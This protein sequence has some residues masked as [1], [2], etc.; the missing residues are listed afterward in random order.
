MKKASWCFTILLGCLL[1]YTCSRLPRA[2]DP[3]SPLSAHVSP[4]YAQRGAAETG[5]HSSLGAV[6]ADYRG[7]DLLVTGMVFSAAALSVL[8]FLSGSSRA[9]SPFLILLWLTA[10]AVLAFGVGFAALKAGSNFLDHEAL[11]FWVEPAKARETGATLLTGGV[12]LSLAGLI[13]AMVRWMRFPE[14]YRGH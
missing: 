1:I 14:D 13:S 5:I 2:D 10:G 3:A 11:A 6:L 7:F 12:L 9:F 8:F 4:R